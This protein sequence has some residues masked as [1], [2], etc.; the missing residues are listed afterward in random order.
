M[1]EGWIKSKVYVIMLR[2][3]TPCTGKVKGRRDI[4]YYGILSLKWAFL[5]QQEK[6]F[7]MVNETLTILTVVFWPAIWW[8]VKE[9]IS[10]Y[11]GFILMLNLIQYFQS[12]C[13]HCNTW[14]FTGQWGFLC[15]NVKD[16]GPMHVA[17]VFCFLWMC[18]IQHNWSI[19]VLAVF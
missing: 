19:E 13:E 14:C 6:H 9:N 18:N 2:V 3:L 16:V 11:T 8:R 17:T 1:R 12:H 10:S 4:L 5:W 15:E 7:K